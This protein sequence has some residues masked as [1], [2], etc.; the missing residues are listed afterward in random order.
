M[1]SAL[2]AGGPDRF[3]DLIL[4]DTMYIMSNNIRRQ[5]DKAATQLHPNRLSR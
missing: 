2:L 1:D 5:C 4:L 3:G